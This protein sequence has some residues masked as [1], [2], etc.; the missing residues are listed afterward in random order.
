[1]SKIEIGES[2]IDKLVVINNNIISIHDKVNHIINLL[3][4]PNNLDKREKS[5]DNTSELDENIKIS[6]QKEEYIYSHVIPNLK[7]GRIIKQEFK[8][9]WK[10]NE[11]QE[12]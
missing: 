6:S 7:V 1:M 11:K 3:S 12:D 2:S 9:E 5:I 4:K 10:T 8:Y